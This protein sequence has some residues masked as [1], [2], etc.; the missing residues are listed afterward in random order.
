[1]AS[2]PSPNVRLNSFAQ[3]EHLDFV[4]SRQLHSLSGRL[5]AP[6]PRL[7]ARNLVLGRAC[8]FETPLQLA[9]PLVS[10]ARPPPTVAW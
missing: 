2:P 9:N 1:M 7:Q 8:L 5:R 4:E 6:Q 10:Q 3:I